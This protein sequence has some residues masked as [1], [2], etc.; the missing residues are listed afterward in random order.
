MSRAL[1]LKPKN[2]EV[3][4]MSVKV[5]ELIDRRELALKCL[6][7]FITCGGNVQSE[8]DKSPDLEKLR[9]DSRYKKLV[10]KE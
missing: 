8:I 7:D 2:V 6:Q 10:V 9:E 5:F 1:K 4:Q 3:L